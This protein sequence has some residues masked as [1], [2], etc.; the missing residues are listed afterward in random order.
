MILQYKH[1][2]SIPQYLVALFLFLSPIEAFLVFMNAGT[3]LKYYQIISIIIM[4]MILVA[5]EKN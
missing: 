1:S 3:L 2:D 4:M 5:S